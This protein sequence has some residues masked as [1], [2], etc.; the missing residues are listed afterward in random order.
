MKRSLAD[1]R[2][3]RI[4][5]ILKREFKIKPSEF[6]AWKVKKKYGDS[7]ALLVATILSQNTNDR[8]SHR[9]FISLASKF[10]IKPDILAKAEEREVAEAI[11]TGG[12]Y[13]VKARKIKEL[14]REVL[15][16][17]GMEEILKGGTE[18][19]RKNLL[20]LPGVGMKTADIILLFHLGHSVIPVDTH[21]NRV[22]K[23]LGL[24]PQS[25]GYEEV[26]RSLESLFDEKSYMDVHHL[27]I[28][29]GRTY[30]RARKP[31]CGPCPLRNL[32]PSAFP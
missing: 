12:L 17:G 23:R 1:E 32:C 22:S 18:E 13:R 28:K 2:A 14:A 30:C 27:L 3:I 11:R 9:A 16:R 29:L 10:G 15:K 21:I 24:A 19:V 8:N 5:D 20:S 4:L 31:V 7:F 25:A 26:R 6:M